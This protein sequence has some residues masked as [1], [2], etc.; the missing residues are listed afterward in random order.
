MVNYRYNLTKI[1]ANHEAFANQQSVV[2]SKAVKALA[3]QI[4]PTDA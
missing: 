1:S 4:Q 3:E 2:A